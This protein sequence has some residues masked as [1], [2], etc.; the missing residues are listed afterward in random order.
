MPCLISNSRR[1]LLVY[2]FLIKQLPEA[3][4]L[5]RMRIK[6]LH[7]SHTG[8]TVADKEASARR[9]RTS[10][11]LQAALMSSSTA[12]SRG[13]SSS[14]EEPLLGLTPNRRLCGS[15]G[16]LRGDSLA[17]TTQLWSRRG[18]QQIST[19]GKVKA[20]EHQ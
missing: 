13:L 2:I 10:S 16:T 5:S 12:S 1:K 14:G 9:A 4:E 6:D 7:C 15:G 11:R 17:H 20:H 8:M 3:N 18:S 19:A